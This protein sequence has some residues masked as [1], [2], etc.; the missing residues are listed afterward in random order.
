MGEVRVNTAQRKLYGER[1]RLSLVTEPDELGWS[2]KSGQSQRINVFD[3][4]V[5]STFSVP[6]S[7]PGSR[8]CDKQ[9]SPSVLKNLLSRQRGVHKQASQ[10]FPKP[11]SSYSRA[12]S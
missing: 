4:Y 7:G 11:V 2:P 9:D 1:K 3:P 10:A 6:D 12:H 8:T 5:L